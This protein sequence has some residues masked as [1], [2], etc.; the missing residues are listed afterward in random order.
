MLDR[1]LRPTKE[2]L[3]VPAARRIARVVSA[4]TLSVAGLACGVGA[5]VLAA[6]GSFGGALALW[7]ANRALDGLDG[8]VARVRGTQS[9]FGGYFDIV[10]DTIVYA[11]LP[12]GLAVHVGTAAAY[13]AGAALM[14]SF[15]LNSATWMYLA[16]V[17]EKRQAGAIAQGEITSVTMPGGLM[18]GTEAI[19]FFTS[20]LVWPGYT[21]G[22]SWLMAALVVVTAG[23]RVVW[24][25]HRL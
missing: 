7:A 16:A 21:V 19:V 10:L 11:L 24:A 22:L 23:Q 9:D 18:E 17:L 6:R 25:W 4:N 5:A 15:Y 12:L 13:A 2:R 8:T 14:A 3:L 20:M 1:W